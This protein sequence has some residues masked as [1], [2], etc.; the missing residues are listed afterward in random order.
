MS[1]RPT[2]A[3]LSA[4]PGG[5]HKLRYRKKGVPMK[6]DALPV[7]S[8]PGRQWLLFVLFGC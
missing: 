3:A 6:P 2:S 7:G 4:P 1:R 5:S 8:T